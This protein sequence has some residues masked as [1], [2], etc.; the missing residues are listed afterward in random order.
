MCATAIYLNHDLG[1]RHVPP[2]V[3]DQL[4][5]AV[6]FAFLPRHSGQRVGVRATGLQAQFAALA[7]TCSARSG[8][9]AGTARAGLPHAA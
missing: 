5:A 2:R 6:L 1:E 7:L 8:L 3:R 4:P 9:Q